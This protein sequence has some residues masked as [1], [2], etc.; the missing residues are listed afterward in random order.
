MKK[1]IYLALALALIALVVGLVA[2]VQVRGLQDV[3]TRMDAMEQ[4]VVELQARVEAEAQAREHQLDTQAKLLEAKGKMLQA[5]VELE[6]N[7][8]YEKA[9]EEM[10][11]AK[12]KLVEARATADETMQTG[13][14]QLGAAIDAVQQKGRDKAVETLDELRALLDEWE[15]R[16][17]GSTE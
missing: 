14:D 5:R 11:R 15:I 17:P 7:Q 13:I 9:V 1:L 4:D 6:M 10:E 3:E 8:N 2:Y 16:V 12:D